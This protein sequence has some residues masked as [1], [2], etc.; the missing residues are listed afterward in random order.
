MFDPPCA[1]SCINALQQYTLECADASHEKLID[2]K[3]TANAPSSKCK[4]NNNAFLQTTAWCFHQ[5]CADIKNSTLETVWEADV[6]GNLKNQPSPYVSYGEALSAINATPPTAV[7]STKAPLRNA[8]LVDEKVLVA[9]WNALFGLRSME[10][11][12]SKLA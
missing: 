2:G 5:H 7:A 3:G 4:A 8:T 9:N 1:Y 10:I 6:V 12:M 11:L